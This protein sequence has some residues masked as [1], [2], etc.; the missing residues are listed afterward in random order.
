MEVQTALLAC[1]VHT[2]K[3]SGNACSVGKVVVVPMFQILVVAARILSNHEHEGA[4]LW[5]RGLLAHFSCL[6]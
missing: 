6:D 3:M 5:K 4:D 1:G 2:S